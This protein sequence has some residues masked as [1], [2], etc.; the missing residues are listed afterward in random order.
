MTIHVY[1]SPHLDDAVFSCGGTIHRQTVSGHTVQLVTIFAGAPAGPNFSDLANWN[2]TEWGGAGDPVA[3]RRAEDAAAVSSLNASHLHLEYLDSMYRRHPHTGEW[4]YTSSEALFEDV[5]PSDPIH[6]LELAR[7]I[8]VHLPLPQE[9]CLHAPLAA[10]HHVDH[11]L[12]RDA[13]MELA[14]HGYQVELYEDL[15]HAERP[16]AVDSALSALP[17]YTWNPILVPLLESDIDA[18]IRASV[19]Y[20]SQLG[21]QFGGPEN[22]AP[23]LRAYALRISEE[24]GY[25]ELHWRLTK[26]D[27]NTPPGEDTCC[28]QSL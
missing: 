13:A 26:P 1:L 18:K 14:V 22:V 6:S 23:R 28:R 27:T 25:A 11:Q 19:R 8:R 12:T 2:H 5:R 9:S 21:V 24:T 4:L 7:G 16:G 20:A 3:V 17:D 10:G 15:P